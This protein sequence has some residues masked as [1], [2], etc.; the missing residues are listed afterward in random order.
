MLT[1]ARHSSSTPWLLGVLLCACGDGSSPG[2]DPIGNPPGGFASG[3]DGGTSGNPNGD[4]GTDGEFGYDD[5]GEPLIPAGTE[6][7]ELCDAGDEAFVKR[8]IQFVHGRKPASIREVRVLVSMI[9]QLNDAGENGRLAVAQG[10]ARGEIYEAR[11]FRYL[12]EELRVNLNG[13]RRLDEC[14]AFDGI[15]NDTSE[16]AAFIR[17]NPA[18]ATPPGEFGDFGMMD[19]VQSGIQL[20]DMSPVYRANMYAQM[21]APLIA[22]NVTEEE[23]EGMRVSGYG[24]TFERIIWG[25]TTECLECHISSYS[26]TN[27][28]DPDEDRHWPIE[29]NF[30]RA[31]YGDTVQEAVA[32]RHYSQFRHDYF[33]IP[34]FSQVQSGLPTYPGSEDAGPPFG[35]VGN[36]QTEGMS[37]CGLFD[38][39]PRRFRFSAVDGSVL[40]LSG[41]DLTLV[42][43]DE[44]FRAGFD[45]LRD[46]G[47]TPNDTGDVDPGVASAYLFSMNFANLMWEEAMGFPL[48]VA[49]NFPRNEAQRDILQ[50]L[51]DAFAQHAYSLRD[52]IVTA[53]THPYFN[54]SP[55][56]VCAASSPY[57]IP[58]IFDPFSKASSDPA[59]RTNGV[60]DGVHRMG[61]WPLVD[62]I[63]QAMWWNKPAM[64]GPGDNE[65]P[66]F[67]CGGDTPQIPCVEESPD[68]PIMRDV[69]AFLSDSEGGFEGTDIVALLRIE[70]T[71]GDGFDPG[72]TGDC[73]GPL[74]QACVALEE[75]FINQLITTAL[76][77]PEATMFDVAAAVKD[78]MITEPTIDGEAEQLA[79][80]SLMGIALDELVA[81]VGADA[82]EIAARQL[83][84]A[85]FNTP[86][87]MMVGIASPDQ[88]PVNDPVLVV[89][90]TDTASLCEALAGWIFDPANDELTQAHTWS[91]SATGFSL[92]T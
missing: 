29:A 82:A 44:Q 11:W 63:A 53:A 91:C 42:D 90:G 28:A 7:A 54:Q 65:I 68:A 67:N 14:F 33:V 8:L 72:M 57:H 50:S 61:A 3:D 77:T 6:T 21:A 59:A 19:V 22:G 41:S 87:F 55:P 70:E 25:R 80:E 51:T 75:D 49:N 43:F 85:L 24:G 48:T 46:N 39:T 78:R 71:F 76:A 9:E 64:F 17:D 32:L 27:S 45:H 13:D 23:L 4:D 62:S 5:G 38:F 15:E 69:G 84:G 34:Y 31:L 74:G 83:A 56:A 2:Q 66:E 1:N 92:E 58:A 86:Q 89:P 26:V 30:E 16:L 88:D 37:S 35:M 47:L 20:D 52:V 12:Y 60:G 10:L 81:N 40:S 73:T 18:N 79:L 36:P